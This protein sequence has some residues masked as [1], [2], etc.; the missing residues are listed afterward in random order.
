[1]NELSLPKVSVILPVF[2]DSQCLELCL[3]ALEIQ[4]YSKN[5]YEVIVVDNGSKESVE[6]IVKKFKQALISHEIYPGSYAARNKG[7]A[8][9][10]GEVLAFTDSDCIPMPDWIEKGIAKLLS[11]PDCGL[12][13]GKIEVFFKEPNYP[14]SVELY[15]ILYAFPQKKYVEEYKFGVTANLFTFKSVLEKVGGFNQA[16]KSGGDYEWG[17]R[18]YSSGLKVIYADDACVAHPARRSFDELSK[19]VTR[20][21]GGHYELTKNKIYPQTKFILGSL[22]DLLLPFRCI[23]SVIFDKRVKGGKQKLKLIGVIV[24]IRYIKGWTKLR[25]QMAGILAYIT[26]HLIVKPSK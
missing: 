21:I 18:V 14:T 1:M 10:Q 3:Q 16:L 5:L 15:D 7:I 26:N 25:L 24:K 19:K 23:P 6:P 20:V 8:L 2:N 22:G 12:V 13:A 17:W 4:T 9:A 11:V